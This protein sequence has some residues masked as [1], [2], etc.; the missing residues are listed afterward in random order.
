MSCVLCLNWVR[1][2]C[3]SAEYDINPEGL[4]LVEAFT[5]PTIPFPLPVDFC[6][7]QLFQDLH[8]QIL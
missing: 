7:L 4:D 1:H 6:V 3:H 2:R 8:A 5:I